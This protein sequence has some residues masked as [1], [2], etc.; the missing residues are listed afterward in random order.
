MARV[1]SRKF[2]E[3][4]LRTGLGAGNHF[5]C[6]GLVTSGQCCSELFSYAEEAVKPP[7]GAAWSARL[8]VVSVDGPGVV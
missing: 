8:G 1:E 6:V 2:P 7:Q 3:V 5:H 4:N